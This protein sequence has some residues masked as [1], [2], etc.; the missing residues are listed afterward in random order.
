MYVLGF[1]IVF[2]IIIGYWYFLQENYRSCRD[3]NN[4]LGKS[5]PVLN[6]FVWPYSATNCVDDIYI[7][8]SDNGTDY[9]IGAPLT[10]LNTPDHVVLT[11]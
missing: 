9:S 8:A 4:I 3:C 1:V 5:T 7:R 10:H 6:P 11:N 2:C